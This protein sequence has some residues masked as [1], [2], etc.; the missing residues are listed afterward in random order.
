MSK[1][2]ANRPSPSGR[3][4][5]AN[6]AARSSSRSSARKPQGM[7]RPFQMPFEDKNIFIILGGVLIIALGYFLLSSG[8][9]MGFVSLT[10]API[11]LCIGYLIVVPY[12]IVYGARRMK[13]NEKL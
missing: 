1:Q 9:V 3:R 4:P 2:P 11:V 7:V 10:L 6:T 13:N 8:P 5:A 12:G